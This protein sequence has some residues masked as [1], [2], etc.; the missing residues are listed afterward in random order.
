[1]SEKEI[2]CH[3]ELYEEARR[4]L[5][6]SIKALAKESRDEEPKNALNTAAAV[7]ALSA[8]YVNL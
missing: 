3:S 4:E 8:A 1:M 2:L 5:L 7:E 6:I